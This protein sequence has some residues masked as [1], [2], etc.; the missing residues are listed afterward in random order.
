MADLI[1]EVVLG[2]IVF[3]AHGLALKIHQGE[4][5]MI[6]FRVWN[7]K[8]AA[9]H[10]YCV[11]LA[12]EIDLTVKVVSENRDVAG[13]G[14]LQID[15]DHVDLVA[16]DIAQPLD[17]QPHRHVDILVSLDDGRR[18]SPFDP[19]PLGI[20]IGLHIAGMGGI[21]RMRLKEAQEF[22]DI[23]AQIRP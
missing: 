14:P 19:D 22:T 4:E 1:D 18:E 16:D 9:G 23:G 20:G 21:L 12:A 11:D 10:M 13:L 8:Q 5:A 7:I 3:R 15:R 2:G 6:T 17:Q